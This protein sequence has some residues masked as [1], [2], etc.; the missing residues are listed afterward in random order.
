MSKVSYTYG[1]DG[2]WKKEETAGGETYY[3]YTRALAP[4]DVVR[5]AHYICDLYRR[6]TGRHYI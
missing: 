4:D 2:N 1:D 6:G 3:Y 5:Y